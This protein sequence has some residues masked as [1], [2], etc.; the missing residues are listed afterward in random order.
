MKPGFAAELAPDRGGLGEVAGRDV[1]PDLRPLGRRQHAPQRFVGPLEADKKR[2]AV[3]IGAARRLVEQEY[4][5][6]TDGAADRLHQA[7]LVVGGEMMNR[8][9][10]P[11]RVGMRSEERRVGKECRCRWSPYQEEEKERSIVLVTV[12][13]LS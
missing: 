6:P 5:T 4:P 13:K 9:A 8:Q 2:I 12:R 10:A 7:E 3:L 1:L 11:R